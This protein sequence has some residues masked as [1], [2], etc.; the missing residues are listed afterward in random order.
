MLDHTFQLN[1]EEMFSNHQL[2]PRIRREFTQQPAFA[3]AMEMFGIPLNFGFALL[4]QMV[5]HKRASLPTL[6]GIL[7]A[8]FEE[9][10]NPSQAAAKMLETS[11][12]ASLVLWQEK[13]TS[14]YDPEIE[15]RDSH[16]FVLLWDIPQNVRDDLDRYQYPLPM[17]VEPLEIR[18]NTETGY[19]SIRNS[20]ILKDNH[21]EDDVCLDHLNRVNQV[22]LRIDSET[23]RLIQNR[24]KNLDKPKP[25]ETIQDYQK[26]VKAFVKYDSVTREVLET[27][28]VADGGRFWLTHKYDKRGRTYCQGYHVNYQGTAWNK[29]VVQ[30]DRQEVPS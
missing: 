15:S 19:L 16:E 22:P 25:D 5:L 20:V 28:Q 17:L 21:T 7:R 29:A 2:I 10:P 1:I 6:V 24:W 14:P 8:Y 23:A 27:L 13:R 18:N 4:V 26:R 30:L 3:Q 11:L 12:Q 9:E